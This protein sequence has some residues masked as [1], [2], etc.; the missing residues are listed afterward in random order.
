MQSIAILTGASSGIG[1]AAAEQFVAAGFTVINLSRRDCPISGVRT[2]TT[3]LSDN[4]SLTESCETLRALLTAQNAASV[5]LV[6]NASL[7]LKDR[8]DTTDDAAMLQ[9]LSVNVIGINTLNRALL[10]AMPR[11]SSVLYVGSTHVN[12]ETAC[13]QRCRSA[14]QPRQ[15]E[16]L[17]PLGSTSGD[18]GSYFLGASPSGDQWLRHARESGSGRALI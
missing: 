4:D 9:A 2:I 12:A 14:Q 8:C 17:W 5:C 3:D 11:A 7:M 6:H 13:R 16:Q 10:P 1:A 18:R 15:N